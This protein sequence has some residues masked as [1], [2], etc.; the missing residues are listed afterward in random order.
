EKERTSLIL[1]IY[2]DTTERA[3]REF[4]TLQK[5]HSANLSVPKPYTW[6]KHSQGFSR[7]YLILIDKSVP[8]SLI[9]TFTILIALYFGMRKEHTY[10]LY[11]L[12]KKKEI[13]GQTAFNLPAFTVRILIFLIFIV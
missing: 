4:K 12:E 10:D 6:K 7:S 8:I 5:L 3:E 2:R 9:S 1:R 11:G 13:K